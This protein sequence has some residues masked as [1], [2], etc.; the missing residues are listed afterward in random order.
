[1]SYVAAVIGGRLVVRPEMVWPVWPGCA[2]L[3]AL[4]LL[5]PQRKIWPAIII[6]G[7]AGFALYDLQE[8]LTTRS[9]ILLI[10]ADAVEVVIAAWGVSYVFG[11]VPRLNNLKSLAKYF[12]IAVVVAPT[13]V[14]SV[15]AV[16]LRGVYWGTWRIGFLTEALAMLTL[17]PAILSWVSA[18][19]PW[20]PKKAP[21]DYLHATA[22][23]AGLVV[24]GYVTF[25]RSGE[26]NP[27]LLYALVPL[28][29]WSALRFGTMGASTSMIV[30]A[31]L[32]IWGAV[33]GGGP[34]R[35]VAALDNVFSLQLFLFFAGTSF[36]I[37]AALVEE[38]KQ[39]EQA[40]RESERRFRLVANTAPVMIWMSGLDKLCDY[41]NQPWLDFTGRTLE[42]ELGNG[43]TEGV[44]PEDLTACLDTYAKAFD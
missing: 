30:V 7:L 43:W 22:L 29:L 5:T 31:F 28:L 26:S 15:A 12:F 24:L 14:A 20:P 27:V 32:S 38:Y 1:M 36:M 3:V 41:F 6:A 21:A 8:G 35:G 17:T 23:I 2:L 16:G 44:Y 4:L 39:A 42:A 10:L 37:L 25:V 18:A 34:F 40:V 19:R 9:T 11:G 33:H 13:S